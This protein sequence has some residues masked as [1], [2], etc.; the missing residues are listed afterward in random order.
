MQVGGLGDVVTGLG[1]ACLQRGHTVEVCLPFYEC[2]PVARIEG[3]RHERDFDVPK[4]WVHNALV[5]ANPNFWVW[6]FGSGYGLAVTPCM[7]TGELG[8]SGLGH[9]NTA[10]QATKGIWGVSAWLCVLIRHG[11]FLPARVAWGR[12]LCA[13]RHP[14]PLQQR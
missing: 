13:A 1:R 3:L 8:S 2:L 7:R 6:S 10:R 5:R 11:R 12:L 9:A 4:V 14:Q